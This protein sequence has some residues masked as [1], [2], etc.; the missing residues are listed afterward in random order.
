MDESIQMYLKEISQFPLLTFG[1]E[2]EAAK[3]GDTEKLINSNLRLVVSIAKKFMNR[4]LPLMDLIQEGNVGLIEAAKKYN[5][6]RGCRFSTHATW[7]IRQ[8]ITRALYEQGHMIT[9]PENVSADLKKIKDAKR[10]LYATL[11]REPREEEIADKTKFGLDK[12]KELMVLMYEPSS[13]NAQ[14]SDDEDDGFDA[15]IE[16]TSIESPSAAAEEADRMDRIKK[17][18]GSLS[19]REA[20]ILTMHFF[21]DK[22]VAEIAKTFNRCEERIRQIEMRAYRKLRN[23]LRAKMLKEILE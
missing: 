2:V 20:Q 1:E 19:D 22:S 9:R 6:E 4:G 18:F 3:T 11:Q 12:V 15:L 14:I 5:P 8:R 10:E 16:D 23:P 13:L 21:E 17:V 7:W